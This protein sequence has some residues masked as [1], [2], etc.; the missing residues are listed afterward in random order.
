[1]KRQT[2]TI[3]ARRASS[4]PVRRSTPSPQVAGS[5]CPVCGGRGRDRNPNFRDASRDLY[6]VSCARC[7][8]NG[9][10]P[11]PCWPCPLLT[12]LDTVN[13]SP[14]EIVESIPGMIR[15]AA[16]ECQKRHTAER[17]GCA[18]AR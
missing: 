7:D 15:A 10:I 11:T 3:D 1:M 12:W 13:G 8:G 16:H 4:V 6:T 18:S 5:E 17:R 2:F 14:L 9:R